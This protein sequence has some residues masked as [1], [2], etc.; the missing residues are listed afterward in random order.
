MENKINHEKWG[1]LREHSC[2]ASGKDPLTG[3]HRTGLD[4]YLSFIFPD[5]ND[6]IHD[7]A[8][9]VHEDNET[10]KNRPDY[11]SDSLNLIVEF[12]G[13]PH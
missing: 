1:F 13:L 3:M 4:E 10:H 12:D 2:K 7:K 9:G 11:R 6:W 5:T 8:F